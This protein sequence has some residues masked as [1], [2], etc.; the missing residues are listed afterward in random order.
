MRVRE[1]ISAGG[2]RVSN[3]R[4]TVHLK[5][6]KFQITINS[7]VR[8]G[9]ESTRQTKGV[10]VDVRRWMRPTAKFWLRLLGIQNQALQPTVAGEVLEGQLWEPN[11]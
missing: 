4:R 2:P 1:G 8:G 7:H 9:E 3:T 6:L 5:G 11:K 10:R